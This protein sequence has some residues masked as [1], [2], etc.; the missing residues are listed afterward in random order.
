MCSCTLITAG[1]R[2]V[3]I[4]RNEDNLAASKRGTPAKCLLRCV[5]RQCR[6]PPPHPE[7]LRKRGPKGLVPMSLNGG[8]GSQDVEVE[9]RDLREVGGT[10]EIENVYVVKHLGAVEATEEEHPTVREA[11]G[12][13]SARIRRPPRDLARLVLQ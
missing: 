2:G 7:R 9:A 4:G 12:V 5:T 6:R 13:V 8:D 3:Q 11:G 10:G 1:S